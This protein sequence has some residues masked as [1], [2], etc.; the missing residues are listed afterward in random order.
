LAVDVVLPWPGL[1]TKVLGSPHWHADEALPLKARSW[2]HAN[3]RGSL[4]LL[5]GALNET[6]KY[7]PSELNTADTIVGGGRGWF[8]AITCTTFPPTNVTP[9]PN[10]L[11]L[12][13][14]IFALITMEPL[15]LVLVLVLS[16][17]VKL[18]GSSDTD[19]VFC[20]ALLVSV[21]EDG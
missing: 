11:T 16:E 6:V 12:L 20:E 19:K 7:E 2:L 3:D 9:W 21:N 13:P 18:K 10:S 14:E 1:A 5:V 8:F 4:A 15:V 17:I